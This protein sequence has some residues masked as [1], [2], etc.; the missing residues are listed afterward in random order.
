[1]RL[2]ILALCLL[3]TAQPGLA[4]PPAYA[5]LAKLP[6]VDPASVPM[7]VLV[8]SP[9]AA[10]RD[11]YAKYFYFHRAET[12]FETAFADVRECDRYARGP[13]YSMGSLPVYNYGMVGAVGGAIGGAVADAIFGSA[14]RRKMRRAIL[15]TCMGYKEYEV[16]GLSRDLWTKFNFEEGNS[17]PPE[18]KRLTMLQMQAKVAAG[19]VPTGE[20]VQG[21]A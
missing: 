7:P 4:A 14:Q 10:D 6:T 12:D 2:R 20:K 1:M 11:D 13:S 16:Y 15:K 21:T 3:G 19:P 5:P 17:S 8:F 18:D 9:T